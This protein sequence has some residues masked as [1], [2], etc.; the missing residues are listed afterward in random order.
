MEWT[1]NNLGM[2]YADLGELNEAEAMYM[3]ALQGKEEA[4]R[5]LPM[6]TLETANDPG[7][8]CPEAGLEI[9]NSALAFIVSSPSEIIVCIVASMYLVDFKKFLTRPGIEIRA[10]R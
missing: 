9:P 6:P 2:L 8:L 4:L 7:N 10:W 3:R 1:L 5:V